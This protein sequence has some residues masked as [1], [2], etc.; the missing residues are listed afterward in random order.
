MRRLKNFFTPLFAII[1]LISCQ[2][3]KPEVVP[4]NLIPTPVSM[5]VNEGHFQVDEET[6]IQLVNPDTDSRWVAGYIKDMFSAVNPWELTIDEGSSA[7]T[8]NAISLE[9]TDQVE[10]EEGYELEVTENKVE[11]RAKS[12]VGLFYAVQTIRQLLPLEIDAQKLQR[13]AQW[14][15]PA[16]NIKDEPRFGWR[17]L[18]LDVSRHFFPKEFIKKYLD[19]MARYK[20]NVFHWHLVDGPGWR[21]QIDKYP[22]LTEVGAWRVDKRKEAWDWSATEIGKP[23]DGRPAYGGFYTKDD[24]RE[25]IAYAKERFIE[26]IPEIEMPG[27][28]YA[29]L[30]AYPELICVDND[31]IGNIQFG[32]DAFCAGNEKSYEFLRNVIDEVIELFP[33]KL[34][35][36]G[37]D[38]VVKT[39]WHNCSRCQN[40]MKQEDLKDEE[41]LQSHFISRMAAY[42]E[43]KGKEVIGWDEILEGGLAENAKVM[44]WRGMQGGIKSANMGH[45]VVMAPN[46]YTYFDLYQGDQELEPPAYSQLLLTQVYKFDPIPADIDEDK[47]HHILGGHACLWTETVQTPE[48]AEYM[49]FPRLFA[50]AETVWS[51][52]KNLDWTSFK[53]RMEFNFNRLNE[54]GINYARSAYNVKI[55]GVLDTTNYHLEVVMS[56]ELDRYEIRYTLDGS[57][58]GANA[59]VY[60]GPFTLTEKADI[61]AATFKDGKLYGKVSY[62]E[63]NLHLASG[64]SIE[65]TT[66]WNPRYPGSGKGTL[67]NG[68]TGS[69]NYRDGQWLGFQEDDIE[70][71]IDLESE[72]SVS[73]IRTHFNHKPNSW[74]YLPEYVTYAISSDGINFTE[75]ARTTDV[76]E[77]KTGVNE[78]TSTFETVKA[79]YIK[80]FAKNI[81]HRPHNKDQKAW[82]F[83]D[84]IIVE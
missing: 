57:E 14:T 54:A 58:P 6:V 18:H 25:I 62:K 66:L 77:K 42:I 13:R 84:E 2:S 48:H 29:A 61:K 49:L 8:T 70:V 75:I 63:F 76:G 82:V 38:E 28:S 16:V 65:Y 40:L 45:D 12:A 36:I 43:S 78:Y 32:T 68:L 51:P 33:S 39:A 24:I 81:E 74:V 10:A 4:V 37:G 34:I 19:H 20:L 15:I 1:I 52:K 73:S 83:I 31:I 21:I 23:T 67:V 60:T 17:G 47:K 11:V 9:L 46:S 71:V 59:T 30:A 64:K 22:K 79:R 50:L 26:V 35:H 41:E 56:N 5:T 53:D 27:H 55:D 44:S 72:Q 69:A 7:E 80:V 3:E